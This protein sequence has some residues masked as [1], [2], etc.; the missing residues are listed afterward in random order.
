M[1]VVS[2]S[3][4]LAMSKWSNHALGIGNPSNDGTMELGNIE[5]MEFL[6]DEMI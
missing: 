1:S 5:R 3:L 6:N 4:R 2:Y